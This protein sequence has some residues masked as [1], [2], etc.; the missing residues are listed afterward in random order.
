MRP[1][2]PY[3]RHILGPDGRIVG[4]VGEGNRKDI[5]NA[6]E[7]AHKAGGW[8]QMSGHQRAQVLYYI[9]EN[10]A[11]RRE[12]FAA[13]LVAMTGQAQADA[14]RE[15]D[16][17]IERW[18]AYA[19]WADKY[20][21]M[22]HRTLQRHITLAIPEPIGVIGIGCPDECPLL[23]F[24]SLVAPAVAMGNSVVVVPSERWPL[25]ATDLYQVF[26][27]SDVP[28]GVINIV[29]GARDA[30][31][32]VLAQHDDVDAVWYFGTAEG[33]AM[34]ERASTGNLK[35]TW[36]NYGRPRDWFDPEQGAGHEFLRNATHIKNIWVPYGE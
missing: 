18:F 7:A 27:T 23:A 34:V 11:V 31:V 5:R 1:D 35:R 4:E 20:D 26:D 21:G 36:V 9:A 33:S 17:A 15:V 2:A 10:L 6:V 30:L 19:A 3:S 8:R 12:E 29:T 22:V 13:R 32:R 28:G 25:A 16:A 14:L 24:V